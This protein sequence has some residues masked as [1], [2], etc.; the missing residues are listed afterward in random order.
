MK[1]IHFVVFDVWCISERHQQKSA[2]F[3]IFPSIRDYVTLVSYQIYRWLN[4]NLYK[5]KQNPVSS[6][7]VPII[8]SNTKIIEN[9]SIEHLDI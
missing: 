9:I 2:L 8:I 7:S 6:T 1:I 5:I 3:A 4:Q